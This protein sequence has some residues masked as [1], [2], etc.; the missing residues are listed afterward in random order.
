M[1]A[2]SVKKPK[3]G[4]E[5]KKPG[6]PRKKPIRPPIPKNGIATTP[7]KSTNAMELIYDDPEAI[8][9]IFALFKAMVVDVIKLSFEHSRVVMSTTDHYGKSTV[10]VIINS[11]QV[12]HYYCSMPF[13]IMIN[14][15]NMEKII[16]ILDKSYITVTLVSKI[17]EKNTTLHIIYK[18][19][20]KIDEYRD[21]DLIDTGSVSPD[22]DI[23][24][25]HHQIKFT[26]PSR[27]FKKMIGD[28]SSFT[29]I[30]TFEKCGKDGPMSYNYINI[31]KTLKSRHIVKDPA[32]IKLECTMEPGDI[33]GTTIVLD[34]IKALSGSLLSDSITISADTNRPM[35][36]QSVINTGDIVVKVMTAT[37]NLK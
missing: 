11:A 2:S 6:R 13:T 9:K 14:S 25:S 3:K 34:Y 27:F 18:N 32:I 15:K 1:N 30:L 24:D 10:H 22:M 19:D 37:V 23:D 4:E 33:F 12:N 35:I 31:D 7:K 17:K 21:L 26:L 36:F 20:M 8:K 29:D 5:R 16:R 28:I